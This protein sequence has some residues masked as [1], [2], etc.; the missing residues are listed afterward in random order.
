[1]TQA[2]TADSSL[3]HEILSYELKKFLLEVPYTSISQFYQF[4]D[5]RPAAER[6]GVSCVWQSYLLG[7]R[8]Q[9][10]GIADISYHVDGRHVAIVCRDHDQQYLI[11]PYL[12]HTTPLLIKRGSA[13]ETPMG[14]KNESYAYPYR[15][16]SGSGCKPAKLTLTHFEEANVVRLAYTRFSQTKNHYLVSRIFNLD[17]GHSIPPT[18]PTREIVMPLLHHGEQNNLSIRLLHKRDH[19]MY[20]LIYPIALHHNKNIDSSH[21]LARD[22]DGRMHAFGDSARFNPIVSGMCESL[23]CTRQELLDFVLDGV[24]IYERHAPETIHYANFSIGDE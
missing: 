8:L 12:L 19:H 5:K 9:K 18:P 21:L 1:M 16:S 20:E 13:V 6:F 7:E 14:F 24:A 22:N 15:R 17:L 11:D 3:L 10:K 2:R 23:D 4:F